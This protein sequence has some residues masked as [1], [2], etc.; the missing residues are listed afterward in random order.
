MTATKR[1][2]CCGETKSVKGFSINRAVSGGRCTRCKECD[3]AYYQS[4]RDER[5]A[6]SR[7]YREAHREERNARNRAYRRENREVI[8]ARDR[9]YKEAHSEE[10]RAYNRAYDEAHREERRAYDVKRR[11]LLGNPYV[12]RS[13]EI[14][15][16][17]A[18]HSGEP[19]SESEDRY[20]ATSTDRVMDD[21]LALGRAHSAVMQRIRKLRARGVPLARD[22]TTA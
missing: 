10:R 19:W 2:R 7:A 12:D 8:A 3:R 1:C 5:I 9:A 20:L 22:M 17:Y 14:S 6:Y 15:R 4:R 16:K 13:R 18:T 21:A 11:A